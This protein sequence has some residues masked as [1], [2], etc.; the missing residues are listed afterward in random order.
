MPISYIRSLIYSIRY[1]NIILGAIFN[2]N[3]SI[4]AIRIARAK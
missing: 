3:C 2:A 4:T 1:I